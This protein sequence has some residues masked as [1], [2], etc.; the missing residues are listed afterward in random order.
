MAEDA[1]KKEVPAKEAPAPK[2][3]VHHEAHP[4]GKKI[5][6]MTLQEVDVAIEKCQK[7]MGGL[8]SSYGQSLVGHRQT[9]MGQPKPQVFKKAA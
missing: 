9:L 7:A 4:H 8:W 3:K 6:H 2:P 1:K 5:S